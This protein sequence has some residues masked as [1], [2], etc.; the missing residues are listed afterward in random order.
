MSAGTV[1]PYLV[2]PTGG[3]T[4]MN[5]T[6]MRTLSGGVSPDGRFAALAGGTVATEQQELFILLR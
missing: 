4:L 6:T 1:L 3:M 2:A 5:P